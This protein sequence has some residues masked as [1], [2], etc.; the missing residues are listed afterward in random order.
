M[1]FFGRA[2]QGAGAI[3]EGM[4]EAFGK[5]GLGNTTAYKGV[6]T[7][8]KQRADLSLSYGSIVLITM[9]AA[10]YLV[11]ASLGIDTFTNK[12]K[13]L[14]GVKTQENLNKWL[15]A[16][17][18]IAITI[19]FTLIAVRVAKKRLQPLMAILFG[20]MGIVASSAVIH[21][22]RKCDTPESEKIYGGINMAVFIVML[23][24]GVIFM[25]GRNVYLNRANEAGYNRG[26]LHHDVY[27]GI[28]SY[29]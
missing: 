6:R 15:V 23:I 22:N 12:C 17:L 29:P 3:R 25:G 9:L 28:K 11:V 13:E 27:N 26:P 10:S 18:A 5:T 14:A 16:T 19:P 24:F 8:L 2:R 21:W 20:I 1:S 7:S 4:G